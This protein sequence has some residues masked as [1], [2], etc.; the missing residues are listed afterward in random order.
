MITMKQLT[1]IALGAAVAAI[2]ATPSLAQRSDASAA[3]AQALRDCNKAAAKYPDTPWGIVDVYIYR[4]CMA[5]HGQ[6]E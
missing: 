1:G 6:S 4:A 3:R 5:Q 2:A